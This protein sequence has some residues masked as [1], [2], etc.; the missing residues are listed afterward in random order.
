MP[1]QSE[2]DSHFGFLKI[3]LLSSGGNSRRKQT[4]KRPQGKLFSSCGVRVLCLL[5]FYLGEKS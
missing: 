1:C 3:W 2:T 4:E 5:A